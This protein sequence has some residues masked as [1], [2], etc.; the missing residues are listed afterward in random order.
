MNLLQIYNEFSRKQKIILFTG[1]FFIF[2]TIFG[3]F[4]LPKIIQTVSEG[5]LTQFLGRK[6]TIQKVKFNPYSL[7][8]TV[9]GMNI[10]QKKSEQHFVSFNNLFV[11]IQSSSLFK[12]GPVIRDITIDG[13]SVNAIRNKDLTYNF[14]D[15]I[16]SK[17]KDKTLAEKSIDEAEKKPPKKFRFSVSNIVLNNGKII[18]DDRPKNKTHALTEIQ[19]AIPFVSNL[20]THMD[21]F[22]TPHFSVNFNGSPIELKAQSKPFIAS[23]TT[24]LDLDLKDID[25]KTYYDYI[26]IETN[27]DLKSG[28]LDLFCSIE[29]SQNDDKE[30]LPQLFLSGQMKLSKIGITD[31]KTNPIFNMSELSISLERS[32]VLKGDININEIIGSSPNVSLSMEGSNDDLSKLNVFSLIPK[33]SKDNAKVNV[34]TNVTEP[35]DKSLPVQLNCNK[36]D[37]NNILVTLKDASSKKEI[38]FLQNFNVKNLAVGTEQKLVNIG[39][40]SVQNG[41]LNIYRLVDKR[42]NLEVMLPQQEKNIDHEPENK[43]SPVWNAKIN[44][45]EF[46]TLSIAANDLVSKDKGQVLI[47][48][49]AFDSKGFS[50][51]KGKRS[52]T[53]LGFQVNKSGRVDIAGQVGINPLNADVDLAVD[54]INLASFQPFISEYLNLVISKGEF[55]TIGRVGMEKVIDKPLKA[56]YEGDV[57]IAGFQAV[58]S[59]NTNKLIG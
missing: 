1:L 48:N 38:F 22:V 10:K 33:E 34:S 46:D 18:I 58:G 26:P 21:I 11:N 31:L 15:L 55:S 20:K 5:K 28:I 8:L 9:E 14:I 19:I 51:F 40:M 56:K 16:P 45:I 27:M 42:I 54:K 36:V 53:T 52:D 50:T 41:N 57:S 44:N 3:F 39:N 37:I 13:L 59:H 2:Y 29:F 35:S 43:N 49:I 7:F 23:Q 30:S 25:L 6:V 24:Q 12:L 32:E 4:I 17:T 47:E